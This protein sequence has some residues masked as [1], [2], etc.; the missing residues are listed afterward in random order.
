MWF[1]L[2]GH[3]VVVVLQTENSSD[4]DV[5]HNKLLLLNLARIFFLRVRYLGFLEAALPVDREVC[6]LF[7][8][9]HP[10]QRIKR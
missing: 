2:T 8:S 3:K 6:G 1:N 4:Q 9:P 10:E 5:Y 7:T